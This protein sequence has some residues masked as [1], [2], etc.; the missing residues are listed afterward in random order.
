MSDKHDMRRYAPD[1]ATVLK[2]TDPARIAE[3]RR[4]ALEDPALQAA[5]EEMERERAASRPPEVKG[6]EDTIAARTRGPS[7]CSKEGAASAEAI[8]EEAL[9]AGR[10]RPTWPV[11]AAAGTIAAVLVTLM[12]GK[13]IKER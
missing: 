11:W 10:R 8:D 5:V 6:E 12:I 1:L 2:E 4:R 13:R 9:P 3:R 7:P